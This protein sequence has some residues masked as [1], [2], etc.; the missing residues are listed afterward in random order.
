MLASLAVCV[1]YPVEVSSPFLMNL[2]E[3]FSHHLCFPS[4]WNFRP[5]PCDSTTNF[6]SRSSTYIEAATRTHHHTLLRSVHGRSQVSSNV[7]VRV[8]QIRRTTAAG[9]LWWRG[10]RH[11]S[12]VRVCEAEVTGV[13]SLLPLLGCVSSELLEAKPG[14]NEEDE[15]ES[16]TISLPD[17]PTGVTSG[18]MSHAGGRQ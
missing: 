10:R 2:K 4:F 17:A 14:P 1:Q 15:D 7:F 3:Q 16:S 18:K 9:L 11:F 13:F 8:R 12:W 6:H 5:S